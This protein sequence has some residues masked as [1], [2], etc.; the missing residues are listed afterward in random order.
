MIV[1]DFTDPSVSSTDK[2]NVVEVVSLLIK[3]FINCHQWEI[4]SIFVCIIAQWQTRPCQP[5]RPLHQFVFFAHFLTIA[6]I[7]C[8]FTNT[9]NYTEQKKPRAIFQIRAK[10]KWV[11]RK[12]NVSGKWNIEGGG[13]VQIQIGQLAIH[14]ATRRGPRLLGPRARGDP[15]GMP[16]MQWWM[17]E[18]TD[19]KKKKKKMKNDRLLRKGML[20][21]SHPSLYRRPGFLTHPH[22][23]YFYRVYSIV[24]TLYGRDLW[25]N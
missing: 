10:W 5:L 2:F 23:A 21:S 19:W 20:W 18:R 9:N 11:R 14:H 15:V 17:I 1:D 16:I 6:N 22:F 8:T 3:A 7:T 12:N 4:S 24:R 25:F 13:R